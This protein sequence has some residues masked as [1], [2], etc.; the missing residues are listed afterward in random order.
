[1]FLLQYCAA[2]LPSSQFLQICAQQFEL[3]KW[4]QNNQIQS[5]I[6]PNI[7]T[8][9]NTVPP[10]EITP[11]NTNLETVILNDCTCSS[12]CS[13]SSYDLSQQLIM[14]EQF[15]RLLIHIGTQ[16][17]HVNK[18]SQLFELLDCIN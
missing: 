3:Q 11:T 2:Q 12:L 13:P 10:T 14:L 5:N 17:N 15:A 4:I 8:S 6:E 1:L 18:S 7:E 9:N 16:T